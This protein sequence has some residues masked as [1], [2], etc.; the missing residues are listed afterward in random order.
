MAAKNMNELVRD[1]QKYLNDLITLVA[2]DV[3]KEIDDALAEYYK[4]YHPKHYSRTNQLR[5]CLRMSKPQITGNNVSIQVYLDID[6]LH[7]STPGADEYKTV[8]AAD[9]GLH[10]GW[11]V[12]NQEVVPWE[13]I[14]P[15]T[16][17]HLGG[18]YSGTSIWT[19]PITEIIDKNKIEKWFLQHA[20]ERGL[21]IKKI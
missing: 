18:Q 7:Y 10:G 13:E 14:N 12:Y 17:G 19:D 21:N 2:K 3:E 16:H 1:I 9:V 8:V 4:E 11:D 20:K 5:N 15:A 6:S